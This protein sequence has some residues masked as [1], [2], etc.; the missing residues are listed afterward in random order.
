MWKPPHP[1]PASSDPC[2]DANFYS[3]GNSNNAQFLWPQDGS[4]PGLAGTTELLHCRP[5]IFNIDPPQ[6]VV[7]KSKRDCCMYCQNTLISSSSF[8]TRQA[9]AVLFIR[10]QILLSSKLLYHC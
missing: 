9:C 4:L 5:G 8:T 7:V 3:F 1:P 10:Q 6:T 2:D